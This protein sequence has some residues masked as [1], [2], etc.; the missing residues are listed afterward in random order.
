MALAPLPCVLTGATTQLLVHSSTRPLFFPEGPGTA[1]KKRRRVSSCQRPAASAHF[2]FDKPS[3]SLCSSHSEGRQPYCCCCLTGVPFIMAH[4]TNR[5]KTN[6]SRI[7][8]I[9]GWEAATGGGALTAG[10][11]PAGF[12]ALV[13][14]G[15]SPFGGAG[16]TSFSS[17]L[18]ATSGKT[19]PLVAVIITCGAQKLSGTSAQQN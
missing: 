7:C 10:I 5:I 9:G 8:H 2:I 13:W 1:A 4:P 18:V 3:S 14:T 19:L 15:R 6:R 12:G 16:S 11:P 17:S